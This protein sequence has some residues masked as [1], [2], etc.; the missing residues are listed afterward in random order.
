[1]VWDKTIPLGTEDA[2][3]G[4]DRIRELKTD[5][6][7]ALQAQD[8]AAESVFPG[9]DTSAPVY[10]YRGLKGATGARPAPG[11]YGLFFDT[12]RNMVQRDNGVTWD[13]FATLIPAGTVMV[14][15]QAAAPTGWTKLATQNDKALRVVSGSGGVAGGTTGLAGGIT[16]TVNAH[17]HTLAHTHTFSATSGG[18]S[19]N[20]NV[21]AGSNA[22]I[23][24]V[25]HTHTVSGTTDAASTANTGAASDSGTNTVTL[26]YV[27]VILCSKD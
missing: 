1:M 11:D 5:L 22:N 3:N 18:P 7:D 2:S 10:R 27:D 9:A 26:A 13:D 4:D 19:T 17:T 24:R 12:T 16:H 6:E 21:N 25:D 14:F 20:V 15:Y 23:P 8:P